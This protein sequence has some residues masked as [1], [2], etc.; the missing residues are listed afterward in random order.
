MNSGTIALSLRDL[1]FISSSVLDTS[2]TKESPRIHKSKS[3]RMLSAIKVK[4]ESSVIIKQRDRM[5][6]DPITQFAVCYG[7]NSTN[8]G[9]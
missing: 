6:M 8:N 3:A 4:G 5:T 1:N 2:H 7:I 9:K